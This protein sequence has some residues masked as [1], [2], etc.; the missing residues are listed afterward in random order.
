MATDH[1]RKNKRSER[2]RLAEKVPGAFHAHSRNRLLAVTAAATIR[3]PAQLGGA[4]SPRTPSASQ[5]RTAGPRLA[6]PAPGANELASRHRTV[7]PSQ[8]TDGRKRAARQRLYQHYREQAAAE[9]RTQRGRAPIRSRRMSRARQQKAAP[10]GV[11]TVRWSWAGTI[12]PFVPGSRQDLA[13]KDERRR[14][15]VGQ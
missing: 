2:W 12:S 4:E 13:W 15:G 5:L 9:Q 8:Y 6:S 10:A 11:T 3:N 14:R 1:Q 7:A